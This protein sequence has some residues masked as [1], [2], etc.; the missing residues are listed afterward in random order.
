MKQKNIVRT[1]TQFRIILEDDTYFNSIN[2]QLIYESPNYNNR[3][4]YNDALYKKII[5]LDNE[6]NFYHYNDCPSL[7]I[8][9]KCSDNE[10]HYDTSCVEYYFNI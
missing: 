10:Y 7:I 3:E 9:S 5:E 6:Y 1:Y 2:R 4:E 8:E